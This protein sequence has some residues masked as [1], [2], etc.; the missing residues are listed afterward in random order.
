MS[1]RFLLAA[2]V[3][4]VAMAGCASEPEAA[5]SP[6]PSTSQSSPSPSETT[7]TPSPTESE[8]PYA[9]PDDIDE[10]YVEAVLAELE[11]TFA[12]AMTSFVEE[13]SLSSADGNETL[14][15]VMTS[16]AAQT[17]LQLMDL[18]VQQDGWDVYED[19]VGAPAPT[20]DELAN[21]D[22]A[23]IVARVTRDEDV[24]YA[25]YTR[26]EAPRPWVVLV[27]S[28]EDEL[29]ADVAE[30][31]NATPWR[32]QFYGLKSGAEDAPPMS[33]CEG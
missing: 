33:E 1:R 11:T 30:A 22:E 9:V 28:G 8:E 19:P 16:S 14:A 29:G 21:A 23:C 13:E 24:I 20:V 3:A 4:A 6:E 10:A 17:H 5:P 25:E 18:I 2:M 31:G 7:E 32:I 26:T 12:Q 15:A 27:P